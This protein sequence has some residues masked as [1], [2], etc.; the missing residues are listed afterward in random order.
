MS[1]TFTGAAAPVILFLYRS[2]E[3]GLPLTGVLPHDY[4]PL[5]KVVR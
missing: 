3:E 4:Q 2:N 1:L 5:Y